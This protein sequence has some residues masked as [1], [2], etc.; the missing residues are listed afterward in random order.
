MTSIYAQQMQNQLK[1]SRAEYEEVFEDLMEYTSFQSS[2]EI[3]TSEDLFKFFSEVKEDLKTKGYENSDKFPGR[4][5]FYAIKDALDNVKGSIERRIKKVAE[6][7]KVF[8]SFKDAKASEATARTVKGEE[9]FKTVVVIY[10]GKDGKI[11]KNKDVKAS[12]DKLRVKQPDRFVIIR[13]EQ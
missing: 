13:K 9:V 2:N 3:R 12:L 5:L 6:S 10:R 7:R 11:I 8:T 4:K 1:K